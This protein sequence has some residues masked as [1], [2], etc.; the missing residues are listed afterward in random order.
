MTLGSL[1]GPVSPRKS[2]G[3]ESLPLLVL[4]HV[5]LVC[6]ALSDG[7][8]RPAKILTLACPVTFLQ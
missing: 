6:T 1:P 7:A 4:I 8:K 2:P 3:E 5:V